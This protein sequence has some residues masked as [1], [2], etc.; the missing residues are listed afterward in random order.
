MYAALR[1]AS[2]STDA[3]TIT[4]ADRVRERIADTRAGLSCTLEDDPIFYGYRRAKR[5]ECYGEPNE[6]QWHLHRVDH[7]LF[8]DCDDRKHQAGRVLR[9]T[10]RRRNLQLH[11]RGR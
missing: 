1:A 2:Q 5:A 10:S 9:Y 6:L 8:R 7:D 3:D 11:H 4:N